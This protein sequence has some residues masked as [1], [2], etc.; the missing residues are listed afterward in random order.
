[1][2]KIVPDTRRVR[3]GAG[4]E[5]YSGAPGGMRK[6]RDP[7]THQLAVPTRARDGSQVLQSRGGTTLVT[8]PLDKPRTKR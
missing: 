7:I 3:K 6:V 2:A 1:M 4:G 8:R 5:V